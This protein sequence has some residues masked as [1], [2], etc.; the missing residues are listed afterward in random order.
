MAYMLARFGVE[1]YDAWKERFDTDPI[2]RRETAKGHRLLRNVDDGNEVFVQ[3]EFGSV[4][5]A[6]AFREK[7]LASGVLDGFEVRTEPTV[8]EEADTTEY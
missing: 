7:L 5:D 8:A 6:K 3:L 4:D 2:G 1:D